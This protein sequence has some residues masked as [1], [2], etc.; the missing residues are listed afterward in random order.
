MESTYMIQNLYSDIPQ[1]MY[2]DSMSTIHT[3]YFCMAW[4]AIWQIERAMRCHDINQKAQNNTRK[5][6]KKLTHGYKVAN[7]KKGWV[8]EMK[9]KNKQMSWN[10]GESLCN[11]F[12]FVFNMNNP[13]HP[14]S[15]VVIQIHM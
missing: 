9:M 7:K 1:D 5:R 15:D 2:M 6:K 12:D 10:K 3:T 11:K 13:I 4:C 8:H 14:Y